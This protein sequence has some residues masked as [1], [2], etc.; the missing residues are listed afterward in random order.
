MPTP[1]LGFPA[2]SHI[3]RDIHSRNFLSDLLKS[4]MFPILMFFAFS[5]SNWKKKTFIHFKQFL[6]NLFYNGVEEKDFTVQ[7]NSKSDPV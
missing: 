5:Q 6:P 2:L 3:K 7:I 1:A 4:R